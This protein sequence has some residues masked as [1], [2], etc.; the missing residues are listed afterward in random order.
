MILTVT[1]TPDADGF[2]TQECKNDKCGK[3]FKVAFGIASKEAIA[4]CPYCNFEGQF[5]TVEQMQYLNCMAENHGVA[6]PPCKM[7]KETN[8]AMKIYQFKCENGHKDRIKHQGAAKDF[9]CIICG[10]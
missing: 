6:N 9:H 7:P 1:L 5:W 4:H 3:K 10:C 2:T 8:M